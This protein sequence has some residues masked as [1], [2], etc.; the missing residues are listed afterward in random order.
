MVCKAERSDSNDVL[1]GPHM[2][3]LS[4]QPRFDDGDLHGR[5]GV[6]L[7][8]VRVLGELLCETLGEVFAHS[9]ETAENPIY[10][11]LKALFC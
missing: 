11:I 5:Q 7:S 6:R 8:P 10:E 2:T 1:E 9:P 4:C 3:F